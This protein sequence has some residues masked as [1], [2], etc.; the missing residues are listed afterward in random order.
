MAQRNN[1]ARRVP[2][3]P[4]AGI[5]RALNE[6]GR[7]AA[8][9]RRNVPTITSQPVDP[10]VAEQIAAESGQELSFMSEF[11]MAAESEAL[12]RQSHD[13]A[14]AALQAELSVAAEPPREEEPQVQAVAAVATQVTQVVTD[15]SGVAK[16]AFEPF[17]S[18]PVVAVTTMNMGPVLPVIE[19]VSQEGV[20]IVAYDVATGARVGGVTLHV[21]ASAGAAHD[22]S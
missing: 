16:V 1:P 7:Y 19:T 5:I 3:N 8:R 4:L 18:Q 9:N 15:A 6:Q 13:E 17:P 14:R 11:S 20:A 2:G 12:Q 10:N 21:T 22:V